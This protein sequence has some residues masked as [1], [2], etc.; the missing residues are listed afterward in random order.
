M[1]Y[2]GWGHAN[3]VELN[4]DMTSLG[5]FPDGSTYK[6]ITPENYTEGSFMFKRDGTY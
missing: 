3:V 5:T 4:P 2:G 1:Y 6:E